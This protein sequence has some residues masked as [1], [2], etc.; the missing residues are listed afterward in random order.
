MTGLCSGQNLSVNAP[1][2]S[3]KSRRQI[4]A[5]H[6]FGRKG[7]QTSEKYGVSRASA[8]CYASGLIAE[9]GLSDGGCSGNAW[10]CPEMMY[11]TPHTQ[12]TTDRAAGFAHSITWC[13]AQD[14][15]FLVVFARCLQI[16]MPTTGFF[17]FGRNPWW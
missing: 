1:L 10:S 4:T 2:A 16:Q 12:G 13:S 15:G 7:G 17:L 5:F 8:C 3:Q 11:H 9:D 6:K 14:V